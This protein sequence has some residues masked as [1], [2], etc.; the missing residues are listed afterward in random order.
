MQADTLGWAAAA[1]MVATFS[2]REARHLRPLAVATNVA[3]IGYGAAP[4]LAPVLVLHLVLLPINLWRCLQAYCCGAKAL[5]AILDRGGRVLCAL[6]LAALPVLAGCGGGGDAAA[7]DSPP[8]A[9][10]P[11]S[12]SPPATATPVVPSIGSA[13]GVARSADGAEVMVP[14]GALA[15]A[16]AIEVQAAPAGAPALPSGVPALGRVYAFT[17]H[18]TTFAAPA[19]VTVPFDPAL[20]PPGVV[21]V[22]YKTHPATGGYVAVESAV[23]QGATMR[24]EVTGFSYFVVAPPAVQLTGLQRRWRYEALA[25]A[26]SFELLPGGEAAWGE[27]QDQRIVS[28]RRS[29]S[30]GGSQFAHGAVWGN[31][32]GSQYEVE[33]VS[34]A[35]ELGDG[36]SP[37]GLWTQFR[38]AQYFLKQDES[39][40]LTFVISNVALEGV[41]HDPRPLQCY[42]QLLCNDLHAEV[43][44][45]VQAQD[46][47]TGETFFRRGARAYL[48]GSHQAWRG[49]AHAS[50]GAP[51]WHEEQ[52]ILDNDIQR[53]GTRGIAIFSLVR[54]IV[55]HVPI[56]DLP[57]NRRFVLNVYVHA[58]TKDRRQTETS[59]IARLRDPQ[60]LGGSLRVIHKGLVPVGGDPQA[61]VERPEPAAPVCAGAADPQAGTLEFA[62]ASFG[63]A[64]G[65]ATDAWI[66]V[67]R[68]GG[69]R[70]TVSARVRTAGGTALPGSDYAAQAVDAVFEDGEQ[71]SRWVRIPLVNDGVIEPD[72]TVELVLEDVRG[73]ASAGVQTT[74]T[75]LIVDDEAA[76]APA[77]MFAVGG[78]VSGLAGTGLVLEDRAQ[79]HELPVAADGTFT[80]TQTYGAGAA[81]D[82]RVKAPPTSPAQVCMVVRGSGIVG[83]AD[84]ADI[85]VRCETPPPPSGL[86]PSFG[87][88]GKVVDGLPGGAKAIARQSTG[89]ILATNGTRLVRY[90]ADG[91]LDTSFGGGAGFVDNLLTGTGAE[92]AHIDVHAD[93][94]IV[95]AGRILQ[96]GLSPPFYQMA[97]A[98][99]FADGTRDTSFGSGGQATFRVPL[100]TGE[101]ATRV[102][103]QP[104]GRVVLVGQA[105]LPPDAPGGAVNNNIAVARLNADGSLDAGFGTGGVAMVDALLRDFAF[106]AALQGDGRIVV[107][108]YTSDNNADPSD[109]LFARLAPDGSVE[110]GFGRIPAYSNLSDEA[111]DIALQADGKIVLL[112]QFRG[113]NTEFA[114]VRLNADG[115]LDTGF[116]SNGVVRTDIG[117][118]DD[119][120]RAVALQADGKIVVAGQISNAN[121]VPPSFG[122]VRYLADGALDTGFSSGGV[123]RVPFF[124][125]LDS[126]NDLLVQPD[127]RIVAAGSWRSGF[128]AGI[129]MVRLIP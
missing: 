34:P 113:M 126:A 87:T 21:P 81:Y 64:E 51:L 15:Q 78:T 90:H 4:S 8:A 53:N 116:G 41:D 56:Q 29:G 57:L 58:M 74:A 88:L 72:E 2:C 108:G 6:G 106:A 129:A 112:V 128:T 127:G 52:F 80:F 60:S 121:P 11:S 111:A 96:P 102:L 18:G 46:L 66:E 104:D 119:I 27:F 105:T 71:G 123:L 117:P 20:V 33:S 22:L 103:A 73:C 76:A 67:R 77:P 92:V 79:F 118:H 94:R 9:P 23:M 31:A 42:R 39:A 55:V 82:V 24:A 54:D 32:T 12:P 85:E 13:G 122:L 125:G 49:R 75:L 69:S 37:H 10:P 99:F 35:Q 109:T 110:T 1:L 91:R 14:A 3:F 45:R 86:D 19:T 61:F 115:N 43:E 97:A 93:D 89:H 68:S 25:A 5:A 40:T 26:G 107:A 17:P 44:M 120:P 30:P 63:E 62:S 7:G 28:G 16:T 114:L 50:G 95:V 84:V 101:N 36:N 98:R 59:A 83:T 38:Q 48:S 70:G 65:P 47:E 100:S 124:G